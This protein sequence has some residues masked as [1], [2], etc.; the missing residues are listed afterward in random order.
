V[1]AKKK[2]KKAKKGA[3]SAKKK[4][5][6]HKKRAPV[7]TPP[8]TTPASP[9]GPTT[10]ASITWDTTDEVDMHTFDAS[11]DQSGYTGPGGTFGQ[12]IPN[13]HAQDQST[14]GGPETFVDNLSPSTRT[15]TVYVCLYGYDSTAPVHTDVHVVANITDPGGSHRSIPVT[16]DHVG[17]EAFVTVSPVGGSAVLAANFCHNPI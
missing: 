6:K 15:F 1:T 12:G 9:S 4:K 10:R 2:C 8:A 13:A 5:C 7:V 11:G 14:D 16:L 17:D 3:V